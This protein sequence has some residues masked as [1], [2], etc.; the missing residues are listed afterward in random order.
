MAPT[1]VTTALSR[2]PM[3]WSVTRVTWMP[4]RR[5]CAIAPLVVGRGRLAAVSRRFDEH[6]S[7]TPS[8]DS[9]TGARSPSRPAGSPAAWPWCRLVAV[10][11]AARRSTWIRSSESLAEQVEDGAAAELVTRMPS[12]RFHRRRR[13]RSGASG[14]P[15]RC[16]DRARWA[17]RRSTV[18]WVSPSSPTRRMPHRRAAEPTGHHDV[19]SDRAAPGPWPL[20]GSEVPQPAGTAA[21]CVRDEDATSEVASRSGLA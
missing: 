9:V 18:T 14:R 5:S 6:P 1:S 20:G 16:P 21:M 15:R 11:R 7:R 13:R 19:R 8:A 17:A 12:F 10:Q 4:T 2:S 3:S